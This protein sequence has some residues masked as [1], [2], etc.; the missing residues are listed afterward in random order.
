[1]IMPTVPVMVK[2][3]SA[4]EVVGKPPFSNCTVAPAIGVTPVLSVTFPLAGTVY[5]G[6]AAATGRLYAMGSVT[7]YC[8]IFAGCGRYILAME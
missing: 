1:M 8:R 3:P 6:G 4:P 7:G 5:G 2:L